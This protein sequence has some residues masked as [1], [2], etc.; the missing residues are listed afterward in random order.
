M[1]QDHHHNFSRLLYF[2]YS[3]F[4]SLPFYNKT[5]HV[6]INVRRKECEIIT[7]VPIPRKCTLA[8]K[9]E[10]QQLKVKVVR[11]PGGGLVL[12]DW[13]NDGDVV[14]GIRRIQQRVETPSPW[15]NLPYGLCTTD[16]YLHSA[17]AG[18]RKQLD[19]PLTGQHE[20]G[21][22]RQQDDAHQRDDALEE[23][24]KLLSVEFAA[25]V[26]DERM[27]L[28]QAKHTKGCHVLRGLHWLARENR[29]MSEKLFVRSSLWRSGQGR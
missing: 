22:R 11:G 20:D 15:R 27:D 9:H 19:D 7:C 25:Q 18:K 8:W 28:A 10:D 29:H 5:I 23:N 16:Q 21:T 26:V 2:I 3:E 13:G 14:L 24:F 4:A 1:R 12:R 6:V 17:R